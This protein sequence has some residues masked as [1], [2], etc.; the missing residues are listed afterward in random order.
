MTTPAQELFYE[1]NRLMQSGK[2]L[3]AEQCFRNA[4]NLEPNFSEAWANLGYLRSKA[5][6]L[7]FAE[8]CLLKAISF[9]P[10]LEQPYLILGVM[11]M[12]QKRFSESELLYRNYLNLHPNSAS[13]WSNLG[14]L[15]A[16]LKREAEAEQCY[17][18]A[19][20]NDETLANA[21]FN[22]SYILLRQRRWEEGWDR[23][24]DRWQ[25][26]ML[27]NHFQ[28]PRWRGEPLFGKSL[29][30]GFEAGHGDMIFY[31]RYISEL[32]ARGVSRLAMICHPGLK[33]LFGSLA[34]VDQLFSFSDEVPP[35]GWDYWSPP[36]SLP[37][38]CLTRSNNI[39]TPIP[40]LHA[41]PALTEKWHARLPKD[42]L[43]VGLV[44][45][46]NPQFENDADRS[47]A[48]VQTLIPLSAVS[49]VNLI[50][51][52]KGLGEAEA[53]P[54]KMMA[55]GAL[56]T[57]FAETAA[58]IQNLDL[59]ISVDTAVAHLAGAM[60]KPCWV[61]LPDYRCDWRWHADSDTSPWYPNT[62]TLFRQ[63]ASGE[64]A[65]VIL[66]VRDQLTEFRQLN[67]RH[68]LSAAP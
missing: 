11:L 45:Q 41:E 17:H 28:F 61:L 23:L 20:A 10:D 54:F 4:L 32:K 19:L 13:A 60:G 62:M 26:P 16:C 24:E 43:R 40:Y 63:P 58:V 46:G 53:V 42:G 49:G 65:S 29:M 18:A 36:M 12:E 2:T 47:I 7:N 33:R 1:G 48:S 34:G 5:G 3:V 37:R 51:L 56:L 67:M 8:K 25:Y 27:E 38:N 64:W 50:S 66:K 30:I 52:Q 57:D 15:L 44:W 39:P 21:S 6:D 68:G 55:L 35:T 14:V 9:S 59:V 22:L 31:S